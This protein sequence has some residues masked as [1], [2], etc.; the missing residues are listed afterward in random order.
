MTE[1]EP[2]PSIVD[3]II[4]LL[5]LTIIAKSTSSRWT[6]KGRDLA[7]VEGLAA[8]SERQSSRRSPRRL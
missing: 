1:E 3:R 5:E 4:R 2:A 8:R 6:E 7:E